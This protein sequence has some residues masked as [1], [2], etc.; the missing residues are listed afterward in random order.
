MEENERKINERRRESINHA[1]NL[2]KTKKMNFN[3]DFL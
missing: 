3:D 1:C 2:N